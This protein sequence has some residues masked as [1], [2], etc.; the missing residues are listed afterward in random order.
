MAFHFTSG[1]LGFALVVLGVASCL[2]QPAPQAP[3]PT[4]ESGA[5]QP[6]VPSTGERLPGS[7][8][9][10]VI[11]QSGAVV[12]GARVKLTGDSLSANQEALS[13]TGNSPLPTSLPD[14]FS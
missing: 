10:T 14:L 7:I 8:S 3:V 11:D 6:E 2:G 9:G 4:R 5:I 12:A 13:D 1:P